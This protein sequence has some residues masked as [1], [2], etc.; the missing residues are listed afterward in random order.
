MKLASKILA[1]SVLAASPL[2]LAGSVSAVPIGIGLALKDAASSNVESVRAVGAGR[3]GGVG[4]VG[5]GRVG[6]VG[7][8]GAGRWA[9]AGWAGGP[10]WWRP[11]YGLAGAAL[12]GGAIAASQPRYYGGYGN[13]YGASYYGYD[14][15]YP[16]S[17]SA[18]GY[19]Y[20]GYGYDYGAAPGG[21]YV[22]TCTYVGGPK[23][24]NWSCW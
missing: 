12:V 10:G 1:A 9:G 6:G 20:G 15:G 2:W 7:V 3:V 14:P 8:A 18:N 4:R 23:V 13:E 21:A 24:G 17:T 5:V 22:Q 11:G 16:S 19:D